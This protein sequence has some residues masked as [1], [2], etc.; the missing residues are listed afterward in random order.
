MSAGSDSNAKS[1][2]RSAQNAEIRDSSPNRDS[3]RRRNQSA[4]KPIASRQ[5]SSSEIQRSVWLTKNWLP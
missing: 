3:D 2:E 5:V 1:S 4:A